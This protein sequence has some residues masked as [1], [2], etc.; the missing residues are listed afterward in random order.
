M[1]DGPVEKS[2]LYQDYIFAST[3]TIHSELC[4]LLQTP[5][6]IFLRVGCTHVAELTAKS[7]AREI[8]IAKYSALTTPCLSAYVHS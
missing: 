3:H 6:S 5:Y 2:Q 7:V 1:H 4:M 8:S